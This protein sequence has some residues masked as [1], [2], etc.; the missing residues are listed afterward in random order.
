MDQ[1]R[2]LAISPGDRRYAAAAEPLRALFAESGLIRERIGVEAAWLLEVAQ[3]QPQ[4]PG[5]ALAAPVRAR[6][7]ALVREPGSAAALAVKQ[8][9]ARINHDVKAVEYYVREELATAGAG[10]GTPELGHFCCNSA[11]PNNP[12]HARPL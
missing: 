8:I 2:L 6:A 9:E 5:A 11:E 12:S 7:E 3:A 10:P 1:P 4:L